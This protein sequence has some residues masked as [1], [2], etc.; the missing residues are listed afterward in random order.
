M[1]TAASCFY[2]V[3]Q[4]E[5]ADHWQGK[6]IENELD[7]LGAGVQLKKGFIPIFYAL[8]IVTVAGQSAAS[9]RS[10]THKRHRTR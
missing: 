5:Y 10:S 8:A 3:G 1:P 4:Q 2:L 7:E 6:G 9:R